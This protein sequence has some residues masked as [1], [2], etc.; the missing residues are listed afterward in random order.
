[1]GQEPAAV[2]PS[3]RPVVDA[4]RSGDPDEIRRDIDDTRQ[5]MEGTLEA[6]NDRVNPQRVYERRSGRARSR[7]QSIRDSIMGSDDGARVRRG[8]RWNDDPTADG[9]RTPD[10]GEHAERAK[11]AVSDAPD[12]ARRRTRGNP[13]AAGMIAFG[14]GA[15][16]GSALPES[17]AE[18]QAA[19]EAHDRLGLDDT[20]QRLTD[21]ARDVQG[22]VQERAKDAA[23]DVQASAQSKAQ[24][25]K[26]H[27]TEESQRVQSEAQDAKDRAQRDM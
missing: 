3:D 12:R 2:T 27:A 21:R 11:Q 6:I 8:D 19:R 20:K 25:V 24:D 4:R 10:V 9:D 7:W 13:L 22:T 26:E 23:Q 16:I 1:M 15:L 5:R 14:V 17:D 18:R